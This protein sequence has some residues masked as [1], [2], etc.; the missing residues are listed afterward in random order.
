[1]KQEPL[2]NPKRLTGET[3]NGVPARPVDVASREA[4]QPEYADKTAEGG[5]FEYWKIIRRHKGTVLLAAFS[6]AVVGFL[7]T[8]PETPIYQAHATVEVRGVNENFLNMRDVNPDSGSGYMDPIVDI[9]TQVRILL[10]GSLREQTKPKPAAK[11]PSSFTYPTNRLSAWK[12]ALRL[13]DDQPVTWEAAVGMAGGGVAVRVAGATRIIDV[14]TDSADPAIAAEFTNTLVNEFIDQNLEARLATSTFT[15][16]WLSKQLEELK[17]KLEKSEDQLQSYASSVGLQLAGDS[18]KDGQ[19]ENVADEKFRQLQTEL[20]KAQAD[21]VAA[22]SKYEMTSL[23]SANSL[24]QV[25][26]DPSLQGYQSQL[27]DLRRQLAELSASLTPANPRVQKMQAQITQLEDS[28]EKER[29]NVVRRIRNDFQT[30][31]R[32]EGLLSAEYEKQ[33]AVVGDQAGK[34]IHYNILKREV[35]TNRQI[36]EGMLQK[37]KEAGIAS[38]IR[39]SGY[40]VVDPAKAPGEPYKP[41]PSRAA[42]LGAL[43]GLVLGIVLVMLRERADHSLQQ[44]GDVA[45]YLNLPELGVIPSEKAVNSRRLYGYGRSAISNGQDGQASNG[46]LS[47][48]PWKRN[49]AF[50]T[51]SFQ[52]VLTSIL[53]SGNGHAP[54][55]LVITSANPS[56]GK[57]LI[58]SSLAAALSEIN[59]R[60]VLID[61]DMR[62]PRQHE[63]FN[64]P[65]ERG[66]SDLLKER[67]DGL[68]LAALQQTDLPGL[69][70]L[71]SG[72]PVASAS[73]LLHSPRLGELIRALRYEF[74]TIIIDTPP[75]LH[76]SDARVL[77]QH[78]DA[79][80]LVVRA[81]KTTRDA[82]LAAMC[83]LREDGTPVLGTVLNDW[84]PSS[85]GYGYGDYRGYKSYAKYHEKS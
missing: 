52:T 28:L 66:L 10:S 33:L 48:A 42:T 2:E 55:V 61:A 57:S 5:L 12:K 16:E 17:I 37:V 72:P 81:G 49:S 23:A 64:L 35:D 43:G 15:S 27:T 44:P 79:V 59:Q 7:T 70:V 67:N 71:A 30:T 80:I 1:M 39:A 8:L 18:G 51:E 41:D 24:P 31:E 34:A 3:G 46:N 11:K 69:R 32:R 36:Y 4:Y 56:E 13:G 45:M 65:N 78:C 14:S 73:N 25:L 85:G 26:D 22:Q 60:V 68:D 40:R 74:D 21:R 9:M 29:S 82:A 62:R 47:L 50:L 6:G 63:M 75:M 20:L 84:D 83:K 58:S 77:G 53:F 76:L 38:A 19:K 54:Q